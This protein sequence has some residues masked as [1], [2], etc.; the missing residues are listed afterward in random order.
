MVSEDGPPADLSKELRPLSSAFIND[1]S[2]EAGSPASEPRDVPVISTSD[3]T[4]TAAEPEEVVPDK[5]LQTSAEPATIAD[6]PGPTAESGASLRGTIIALMSKKTAWGN[7]LETVSA[8]GRE[9]VSQ[10]VPKFYKRG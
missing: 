4:P 6:P 3:G 8:N 2:A 10:A 5:P 7:G 9:A 1:P